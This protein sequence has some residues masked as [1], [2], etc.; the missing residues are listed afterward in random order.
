MVSIWVSL[1]PGLLIKVVAGWRLQ[2]WG[3]EILNF[4]NTAVFYDKNS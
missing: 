1:M 2:W 3:R 4:A